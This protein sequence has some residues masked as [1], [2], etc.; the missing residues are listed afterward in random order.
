MNYEISLLKENQS[1]ESLSYGNIEG[2]I[3][4]NLYSNRSR[5]KCY[6]YYKTIGSES[7]AN[8]LINTVEN[9][10]R[11]LYLSLESYF[12]DKSENCIKLDGKNK[13]LH[14]DDVK[15]INQLDNYEVFILLNKITDFIDFED[16]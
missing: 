11:D 6:N 15:F 10:L 16:R 5:V 14:L 3:F 2:Y 1:K 9:S 13:K 12:K 4:Y 7:L 8:R